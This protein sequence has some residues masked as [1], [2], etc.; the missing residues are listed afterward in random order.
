M[1]TRCGA[2]DRGIVLYLLS[3]QRMDLSTVTDLL[4]PRSGLLGVSGESS[5]KK[6]L[7]G[8]G[9]SITCDADEEDVEIEEEVK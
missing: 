9:S 6:R 5:E 1:G 4:Y 8:R 2:L 7:E 3:E